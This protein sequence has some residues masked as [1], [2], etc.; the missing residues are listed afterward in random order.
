[1]WASDSV[2]PIARV[3]WRGNVDLLLNLIELGADINN[4]DSQGI[5]PL[6][7]A[8]KRDHPDICAILIQRKAD[9]LRRSKDGYT[10]LD[11]AILHG[12][13][14]AAYIIYEFDQNVQNAE[15]Y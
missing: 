12:N 8:A 9:F 10:A 15:D 1:M 4:A 11:Y 3:A 6:M 7:W 2:C 5:T 14:S 13:Y